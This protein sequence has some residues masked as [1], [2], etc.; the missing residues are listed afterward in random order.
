[1]SYGRITE[2]QNE[3]EWI[4]SSGYRLM[5]RNGRIDVVR[6]NTV[7]DTMSAN[8]DLSVSAILD[9]AERE[10]LIRQSQPFEGEYMVVDYNY[11]GQH[12]TR[13]FCNTI[14]DARRIHSEI[15]REKT[16]RSERFGVKIYRYV[17]VC[18]RGYYCDVD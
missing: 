18:D 4:L 15:V 12:D 6:G 13:K 14:D 3:N 5:L 17:R 11:Y 7:I 9:A 16:S 2:Q 8:N 10:G 1:M